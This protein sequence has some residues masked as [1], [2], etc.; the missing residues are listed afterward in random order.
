MG[1]RGVDD[2][3]GA[4]GEV[5]EGFAQQALGR[6]LDDVDLAEQVVGGLLDPLGCAGLRVR[7]HQR[8]VA[9]GVG[10]QRRHVYRRRGLPHAALDCSR[11]E[12]HKSAG[13]RGARSP[14]PEE[15]RDQAAY[16][17]ASMRSRRSLTQSP[18]GQAPSTTQVAPTAS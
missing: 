15:A 14:A 18:T 2:D 9:A 12:D 10:R 3:H 1:R 8:D 11:D 6:S 13:Y 16:G 7:V 17:P 4:G 5:A